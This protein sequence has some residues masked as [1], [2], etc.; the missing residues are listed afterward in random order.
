MGTARK[1]IMEILAHSASKSYA[2]SLV[3][4]THAGL[5]GSVPTTS[6]RRDI[7]PIYK[8]KQTNKTN[9]EHKSKGIGATGFL[10]V[11]RKQM[12]PCPEGTPAADQAP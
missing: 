8:H 6:S 3:R 12:L 10:L 11:V 1:A 2:S 7:N 9:G 5:L 4:K